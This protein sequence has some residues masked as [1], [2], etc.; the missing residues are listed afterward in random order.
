MM[1]VVT[2]ALP[3]QSGFSINLGWFKIIRAPD[4]I[5]LSQKTIYEEFRCK[6][7]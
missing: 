4:K 5:N 2:V 7:L 3:N 1:A 6:S